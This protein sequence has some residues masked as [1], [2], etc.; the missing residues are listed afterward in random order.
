MCLYLP[1]LDPYIADESSFNITNKLSFVRNGAGYEI[2]Y[3][4]NPRGIGIFQNLGKNAERQVLPNVTFKKTPARQIREI[5]PNFVNI[6][7]QNLKV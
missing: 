6:G 1:S 3:N 5:F 7:K 2:E 4:I